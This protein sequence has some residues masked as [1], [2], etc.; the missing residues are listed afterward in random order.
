MGC[1]LAIQPLQTRQVS[2]FA[3]VCQFREPKTYGIS[4]SETVN[5][6]CEVEADP[7][8]VSYRWSLDS[9]L[10][11]LVL[12]NWSSAP[13]R[14]SLS[15]SPLTGSG[16]GTLLCWGRNSVGTQI[17]PCLIQIVLAATRGLLATD[18][19]ILNHGQVT[20]TIPEMAPPSPN[21][22]TTPTGG[23]FGSRQI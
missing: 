11:T 14:G 13:H 6:T 12:S 22:P 15:Y 4:V 2:K 7:L 21:Y 19:V 17:E 5:A 10:G 20:W 1:I 3:P 16:Y 18:H 8:E 9:L 23:R